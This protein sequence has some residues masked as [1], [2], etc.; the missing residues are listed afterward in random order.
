VRLVES[1]DEQGGR[2]LPQ[3]IRLIGEIDDQL[4]LLAAGTFY[5]ARLRE[6]PLGEI[7]PLLHLA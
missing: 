5:L 6:P 3:L 4:A 1:L 7:E 2:L